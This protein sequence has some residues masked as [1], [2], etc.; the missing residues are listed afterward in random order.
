M[1][2]LSSDRSPNVAT[3]A[4]AGWVRVPESVPPLGFVPIATVTLPTKPVA[5]FPNWSRAVTCTAGVTT[6]PATTFD[7]CTV[8]TRALAAAGDTLNVVLVAPV[9]PVDAAV[10][11]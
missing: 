9:R 1:P 4:L 11:V 8:K 6:V 2:T 10:S 3:P 5:V 7:G